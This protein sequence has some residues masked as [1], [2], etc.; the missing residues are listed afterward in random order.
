MKKDKRKILTLE[1]CLEYYI[2]ALNTIQCSKYNSFDVDGGYISAWC[3]IQMRQRCDHTRLV[4]V[5]MWLLCCGWGRGR[6]GNLLEKIKKGVTQN[7]GL[8]V[9][10]FGEIK[11][12]DLCADSV[13]FQINNA[14]V[15]H[16]NINLGT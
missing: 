16:D 4:T 8:Q 5:M 15:V 3:C 2:I 10:A 9:S 11:I 13:A 7:L 1:F 12:L 6:V 14:S